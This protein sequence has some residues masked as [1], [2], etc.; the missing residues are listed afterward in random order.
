MGVDGAGPSA[1]V[2]VAVAAGAS[3]V[4]GVAVA[5]GASVVAGVAVTAGASVVAGAAVTVG[6][7]VAVGVAVVVGPAVVGAALSDPPPHA[8]ANRTRVVIHARVLMD[9]VVCVTFIW[10]TFRYGRIHDDPAPNPIA[11][12]KRQKTGLKGAPSTGRIT[13]Y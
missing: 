12:R 9:S 4:V 3:V 13:R 5:A 8:E 11:T 7:T 6:T 1:V 2:G 10:P